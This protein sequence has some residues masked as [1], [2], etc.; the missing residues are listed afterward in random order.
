[1]VCIMTDLYSIHDGLLF[2]K[3]NFYGCF[4]ILIVVICME[5]GQSGYNTLLTVCTLKMY[6]AG[7]DVMWVNALYTD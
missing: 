3:H 2:G 7:D 1:M 4:C 6:I 5:E